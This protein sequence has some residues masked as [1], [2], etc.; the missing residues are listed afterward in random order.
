MK[1]IINGIAEVLR[2]VGLAGILMGM[3]ATGSD[4]ILGVEFRLA[5]W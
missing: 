4:T 1:R 3:F 5:Y 2:N